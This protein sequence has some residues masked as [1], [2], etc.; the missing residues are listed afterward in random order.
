MSSI[1]EENLDMIKQTI[2]DMISK[3]QQPASAV[4]K[5][6]DIAFAR[7]TFRAY[8]NKTPPKDVW[9]VF[10]AELARTCARTLVQVNLECADRITKPTAALDEAR[11]MV[12]I[13][14]EDHNQIKTEDG[15]DQIKTEGDDNQIKKEE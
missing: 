2:D 14:E 5:K 4:D 7:D 10:N 9:E 12:L 15:D 6:V 3:I 11:R 13:E 8:L 1:S